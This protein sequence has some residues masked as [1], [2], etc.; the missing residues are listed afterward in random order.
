[1]QNKKQK[2]ELD[3]IENNPPAIYESFQIDLSYHYGIG[4][5]IVLDVDA[6]H[7]KEIE[8]A[9]TKFRELGE[10]NWQAQNPVPRERLKLKQGK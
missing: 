3:I 7:R 9:I 5:E 4:L 10:K 6:I 8:H 1:L 2:L